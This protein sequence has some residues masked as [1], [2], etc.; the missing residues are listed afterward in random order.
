MGFGRLLPFGQWVFDKSRGQEPAASGHACKSVWN[1]YASK[2]NKG[3]KNPCQRL[4][5]ICDNP[6]AFFDLR[7]VAAG[8]QDELWCK[9]YPWGC[10]GKCEGRKFPLPLTLTTETPI[11]RAFQAN[12][13]GVRVE[14]EKSFFCFGLWANIIFHVFVAYVI[15]I[16]VKGHICFHKYAEPASPYI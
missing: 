4:R 14:K 3:Q 10:E 9:A 2:K 15:N 5:C 8:S 16:K 12:C 6:W 1:P 7:P 13:E 11:N